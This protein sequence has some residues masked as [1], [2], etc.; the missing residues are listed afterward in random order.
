MI[1]C[2]FNYG[3][4]REEYNLLVCHPKGELTAN[5]MNDIGCCKKCIQK[6]GIVQ[7]D[8]FHDLTDITA[9]NLGFDE[10]REICYAESNFRESAPPVKACYLVPNTLLYGTIRMY[11]ALIESCGVEVHVS[12][13]INELAGILGVEKSVLTTGPV[14]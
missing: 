1:N 2:P 12:Y 11:Q 5:R 4:Q 13:D 9:V 14:A 10:V 8:R 6:A 3:V 7:I